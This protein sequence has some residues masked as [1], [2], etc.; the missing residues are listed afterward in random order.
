M[1]KTVTPA[2]A[3]RALSSHIRALLIL[4]TSLVLG[5]FWVARRVR[6]RDVDAAEDIVRKASE[7]PSSLSFL[8]GQ[9]VIAEGDSSP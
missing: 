9:V 2:V 7:T 1:A 8:R 6:N 5:G 3:R 4:S